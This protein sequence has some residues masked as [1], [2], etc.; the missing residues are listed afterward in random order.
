MP[1]QPASERTEEAT[2]DRLRKAREEGQVPQNRELPSAVMIGTLLIGLALLGE[3]IYQWCVDQVRDG[4]AVRPP[5][6]VGWG[7]IGAALESKLSGAMTVTAPFLLCA[8]AGSIFASLLGSGWAFSPKAVRL[9]FD[10]IS[11]VRGMKNLFSMQSLVRLGISLAKLGVILAI[12]YYYL[13]DNIGRCCALRWAEP[14]AMA[15]GIST[16]VLGVL[17]RMAIGILAIAGIDLL[18]QRRKYR[19]DLRMTRQEVK[20]ERKQHELS[21]ELRGRIRTTQMEMVRKRMLQD[22][23]TADVI[24]ANPTHVAVA[25]RYDTKTMQAPQ[26]VAKGGDLVCE[27]IKEIARTHGVPIVHRPELARAIFGAVEVG[28][29]IPE[30]LFVAVAEVLAMIYRLKKQRTG[31]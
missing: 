25:L 28:Q 8:A 4:V 3:D 5:A 24:V 15:E 16:L 11:P 26:V 22:V 30:V 17:G 18:Y 2:P 20:E 6:T 14:H 7:G 21:P 31:G 23:P 9:R 19:K 1:D 13:R 27:K 12:V 29:P 10:R